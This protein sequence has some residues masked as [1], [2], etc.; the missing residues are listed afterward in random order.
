[1]KEVQSIP[2]PV[3]VR[4]RDPWF[5]DLF[6]GRKWQLDKSEWSKRYRSPRS[7]QSAI[8]QAA[9]KRG[10]DVVVA[11]RDQDVYVHAENGTAKPPKKASQ[12]RKAAAKKATPRKAA[13]KKATPRKAPAKKSAK[14][15][16]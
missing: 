7:A 5:D 9:Q 1:M 12:P 2:D 6:N 3:I 13:A 10:L 8:K 16:A 15:G 4:E 11:I 14:A